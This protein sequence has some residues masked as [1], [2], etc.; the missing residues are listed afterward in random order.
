MGNALAS[1]CWL[2]PLEAHHTLMS[3]KRSV[4]SSLLLCL[5]VVGACELSRATIQSIGPL[6]SGAKPG[7][8]EGWQNP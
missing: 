4:A 7:L 5:D 6:G 1:C 3:P 8:C 2:A